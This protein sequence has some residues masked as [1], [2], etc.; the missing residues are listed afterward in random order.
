MGKKQKIT[1]G[2]SKP[3]YDALRTVAYKYVVEEGKT[4]KEAARILGV[5]EKAMSDW[6]TAGGWKDMRKSRQS[7]TET[8]CENV[9]HI[10][11][12][13]SDKRLQLEYS[14]NEARD[15]GDT[16]SEIRLRKEAAIVSNDM[17]YQKNVLTELNRG[18]GK[19]AL[20]LGETVDFAD[21]YYQEMRAYDADLAERN[22][23]F[24]TFYIRK[25]TN[26]LG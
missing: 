11:N 13:L 19:R 4:Q 14:I 2:E 9:R 3:N 17:I 20:T 7:S 5:T 16:D 23:D 25:K 12:L 18:K 22:F 8:A 15:S 26:E 6:A 21:D 24:H 1:G 10:I